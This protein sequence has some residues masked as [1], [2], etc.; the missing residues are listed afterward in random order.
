MKRC[1]SNLAKFMT[2]ILHRLRFGQSPPRTFSSTLLRQFTH[3]WTGAITVTHRFSN[4][5]TSG[6]GCTWQAAILRWSRGRSRRTVCRRLW[7]V[8]ATLC[9]ELRSA[10]VQIHRT[11]GRTAVTSST[12]CR[13]PS[14]ETRPLS[15]VPPRMMSVQSLGPCTAGSRAP[16]TSSTF[17]RWRDAGW[18]GELV[19]SSLYVGRCWW[20]WLPWRE[21]WIPSA[22]SDRTANLQYT[23]AG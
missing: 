19:S 21:L 16:A 20:L 5:T 7:Q 18:S 1:C 9:A 15:T 10:M 23:S 6:C 13:E 14:A 4:R 2:E 3:G 8:S 17:C 12:A 22:W 11:P